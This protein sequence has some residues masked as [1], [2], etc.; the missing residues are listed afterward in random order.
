MKLSHFTGKET[1]AQNVG[2]VSNLAS[3]FIYSV[4]AHL[5]LPSSPEVLLEKGLDQL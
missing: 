4:S 3:E 5:P 1:E 2:N